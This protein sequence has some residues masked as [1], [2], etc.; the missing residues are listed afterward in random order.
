MGEGDQNSQDPAGVA[1]EYRSGCWIC[2]SRK[3]VQPTRGTVTPMRQSR[4]TRLARASSLNASVLLG[5]FGALAPIVTPAQKAPK[6]VKTTA[7]AV[8]VAPPE[9]ADEPIHRRAPRYAWAL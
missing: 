6:P 8:H 1:F 7:P 5:N 4:L 2:G 3:H 9:T